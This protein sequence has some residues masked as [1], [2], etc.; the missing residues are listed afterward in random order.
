MT[1][2]AT[3]IRNGGSA[4]AGAGRFGLLQRAVGNR[5]T[6][7]VLAAN[8]ADLHIDPPDSALE[9]EADQIADHVLGG[10]T[11]P[12]AVT[13]V[14]AAAPQLQR[15]CAECAEEEDDETASVH[16]KA[17]G[18]QLTAPAGAAEG[19]AAARRGGDAL[20]HPVRAFFEPR[21]GR[22][23][24][25]VRVHTD[26]LAAQSA[27][28]LNAHAYTA[29]SDIVFGA[30][31]YDP[32][33]RRGRQLLAH[34]IA[35]VTQ[36][37]S[38][39]APAVQ[40]KTTGEPDAAP[41]K[42]PAPATGPTAAAKASC[43]EEHH[44]DN[45]ERE[46][47]LDTVTIVELTQ[48]YCS[49]CRMLMSTL[50]ESC[51]KYKDV[52]NPFRVRYVSV[53]VDNNPNTWESLAKSDG[54]P[55]L[56]FYVERDLKHHYG[57]M[58][59]DAFDYTLKDTIQDASTSPALKGFIGGAKWG[60]I[61]ALVG[62]LLFSIIGG[63]TGFLAGNWIILGGLLMGAGIDALMAG[64]G[65][66]LGALFGTSRGTTKLSEE[67]VREVKTYVATLAARKRI[68][69]SSD[70]DNLA[71][72]ATQLFTEDPAGFPLTT[73]VK[74]LL[75]KEMLSG[76]TLDA[77]ERSI[78]KLL[79]SA[80]DAELLDLLNP[81]KGLSLQDVESDIQGAEHKYFLQTL[82][83]RVPELK[84]TGIE[85]SGDLGCGSREV[86]MI[87]FARERSI[88]VVQAAI[89]KINAFIADPKANAAVGEK[90]QCYFSG[91]GQA[92]IVAVR[93]VLETII[94]QGPSREFVCLGTKPFL[95]KTA[96]GSEVLECSDGRSAVDLAMSVVGKK[97]G[98]DERT[99]VCPGFF[100]ADF[101]LQV[102]TVI[103]EWAHQG[104]APEDIQYEPGCRG[105]T[106]ANA[107]VNADS[108]A[109][110]AFLLSRLP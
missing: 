98:A 85:T 86:L 53:D 108:Y 110:L 22:D 20:P 78:M 24:S 84:L 37:G 69:D 6:A 87:N 32:G 74:R 95:Y 55:H 44:G 102:V 56:F 54:V 83:A 82:A 36:Q 76:P 107:K 12:P 88:P 17:A 28:E 65:A 51:K 104:G 38:S 21:F 8:Q 97:G 62:G 48:S 43:I 91:A 101:N 49:P 59:P 72:D 33:S 89:A 46:L 5:T 3:R 26:S 13:S 29:G 92:D 9:R 77:D 14:A 73:D 109:N 61:P 90:I 4:A 52:R 96:K 60:A 11:P 18:G 25:Q 58:E 7:N 39:Q 31:Q 42:G 93:G 68:V 106:L 40:R 2:P 80:S 81:T 100:N 19:V 23:L 66:L 15:M 1:R 50:E 47:R 105:L 41:A 57:F 30:G 45:I 67:R 103:H 75:I 99:F 10:T 35:H 34:E 71:R 70:A 64:G 63:L 27:D 94:T 16:R 79:E